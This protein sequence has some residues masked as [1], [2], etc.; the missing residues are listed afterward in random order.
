MFQFQGDDKLEHRFFAVRGSTEG[1]IGSIDGK[2]GAFDGEIEGLALLPLQRHRL[3]SGD[4]AAFGRY[5]DCAKAYVLPAA[6]ILPK[7]KK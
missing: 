5:G 7:N 4:F 1:K 3:Y 2:T 6:K